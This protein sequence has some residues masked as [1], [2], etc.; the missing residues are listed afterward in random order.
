MN[1]TN[2]AP[3]T[4]TPYVPAYLIKRTRPTYSAAAFNREQ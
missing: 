2:S 4:L 3:S 1:N